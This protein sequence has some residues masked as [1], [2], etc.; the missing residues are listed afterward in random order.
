MRAITN[1]IEGSTNSR[2]PM[3]R[4]LTKRVKRIAGFAILQR[5]IP[6][7]SSAVSSLCRS[8]HDKANIPLAS[9]IM[10]LVASKNEMSR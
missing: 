1:R 2:F 8:S 4:R 10:G 3:A 6:A 7:A 9:E 5:V